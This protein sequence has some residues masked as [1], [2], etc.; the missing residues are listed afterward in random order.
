MIF[1]QN[2]G[3]NDMK[4]NNYITLI[5]CGLLWGSVSLHTL[6]LDVNVHPYAIAFLRLFLGSLSLLLFSMILEKNMIYKFK[7][8]RLITASIFMLL[9]QATYFSSIYYNGVAIGTM[10]AICSAPIFAV[11]FKLIKMEKICHYYILGMILCI[12]GSVMLM[13][14]DAEV[15]FTGILFGLASGFSYTSYVYASKVLFEHSKPIGTN[16]LV[17]LLSSVFLGVYIIIG[18]FKIPFTLGNLIGYTYLGLFATGLAYMFF[19]IGLKKNDSN[20]VILFSVLEPITA[21]IIALLVFK[22][23]L[24]TIGLIGL[25]T[26][27]IGLYVVSLKK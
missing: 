14:Q 25:I 12:I 21:S 20:V 15:S 19:S 16:G 17:F 11:M 10:I 2:R 27:I 8:G 24:T 3:E 9:Y 23:T 7:V 26:C 4:K 1:V 13:Y 6:F 22:E 5:L 18:G